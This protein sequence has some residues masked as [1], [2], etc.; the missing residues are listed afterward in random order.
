MSKDRRDFSSLCTKEQLKKIKSHMEANRDAVIYR[1]RG[2]QQEIRHAAELTQKAWERRVGT[3]FPGYS[4]DALEGVASW[5]GIAREEMQAMTGG[6]IY[7]LAMDAIAG[8]VDDTLEDGPAPAPQFFR[9]KNELLHIGRKNWE[10]CRVLWGKDGVSFLDVAEEVWGDPRTK[11]STI[12][13]Q[14]H[15][16]NGKLADHGIPIAY[17]VEDE[18]IHPVA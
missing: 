15:R 13:S 16:L 18:I 17:A 11:R 14:L 10:L 3:S 4:A 6:E 2:A 12:A 1:G 7:M 9:W 8:P 5:A